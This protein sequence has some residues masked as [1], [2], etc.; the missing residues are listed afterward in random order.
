MMGRVNSQLL[1]VVQDRSVANGEKLQR[2]YKL[3]SATG[4]KTATTTTTTTAAT[5]TATT[6]GGRVLALDS[7]VHRWFNT[8]VRGSKFY[9]HYHFLIKHGVHLAHATRFFNKL[10][11]GS[12]VE[13]QLATFQIFLINEENQQVFFEKFHRLYTFDMMLQIFDRLIARRDFRYVKFY[14]AALTRKMSE[15]AT[16]RTRTVQDAELMYIK[17]NNSLLYYLLMEGNVPMFLRTFKNEVEYIKSSTLQNSDSAEVQQALLKPVHLFVQM[18]RKNNS[19]D[20]IFELL[21]ALQTKSRSKV[22]NAY[23]TSTVASTI[24]TFNDPTL[25]LKFLL[26]T[27]KGTK[28]PE[29]LNELGLWR[30]IVHGEPGKIDPKSLQEDR[31]K[32]EKAN[33]VS[34]LKAMKRVD[35]VLLTELYRVFLSYSS[36]VMSPD[37]FRHCCID[38][39][40]HYVQFCEQNKHKL[41]GWKFDTG[42]LNVILYHIR[43][44]LRDDKLAYEVLVDFYG[45]ES[46]VQ[47]VKNTAKKCPFSMVIYDNGTVTTQQLHALLQLMQRYNVPLSF[48]ICYTMVKRLLQMNEPEQ[49]FEWYTRI[50]ESGFD[51]RHHGLVELVLQQGWSLPHHFNH[52]LLEDDKLDSIIEEEPTEECAELVEDVKELMQSV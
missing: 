33:S 45:R 5:T 42:V 50:L 21:P 49:A 25:M 10:L 47:S 20:L 15:L 9:S 32:F 23:L 30:Y 28:F 48:Q 8:H 38:L 14:L 24:R 46:M 19:P 52:D 13:F 37:K 2:L 7:H 39:Y 12:E 18:L 22:F 4:S 44:R 6:G 27:A 41:R 17:F 34:A 26:T 36:S 40:S 35:V 3:I 11:T 31:D 16:D 29:L 43:Y 51:V 1:R